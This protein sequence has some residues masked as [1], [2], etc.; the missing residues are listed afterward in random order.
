MNKI[1]LIVI[2]VISLASCQ[3]EQTK[4]RLSQVKAL[5]QTVD[6]SNVVFQTLDLDRIRTKKENAEQQMDYLSKNYHDTIMANAKYV[7][8]YNNNFKLM[9]KILKGSTRLES[10]IEFSKSQL[11]HLYTDIANGFAADTM[12][13]KH[14]D[15][16][17]KAVTKIKTTT[18]TLMDW[19]EKTSNRY[20]GMVAPIDSIIL[21]LKSQGY[22]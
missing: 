22:R 7:N 5:Q 21:S 19:D 11:A 3:S 16:E 9:R 10:E 14:F 8:A 4:S 2:A 15:T 1:I 20:N 17:E 6:S 12:Y 13:Q 18:K